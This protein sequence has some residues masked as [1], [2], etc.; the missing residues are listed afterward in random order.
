[1]CGNL[2]KGAVDEGAITGVKGR[3]VD[4]ELERSVQNRASGKPYG[5]KEMGRWGQETDAVRVRPS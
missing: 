5:T 4:K 3:K 2:G 1:V